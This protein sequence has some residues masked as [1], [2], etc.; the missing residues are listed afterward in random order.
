MSRARKER[1]VIVADFETSKIASDT[2]DS[3]VWCWG[4]SRWH[5]D[6]VEDDDYQW[7]LS[8]DTFMEYVAKQKRPVN[9][10]FH[11]LKFDGHFIVDWLL[12]T[13]KRCVDLEECAPRVGEFRTTISDMGLWYK[14]VW[15][16]SSK[17]IVEFRDSYKLLPVSVKALGEMS[18][19]N[20]LKGDIE[21]S[22]VRPPGYSPTDTELDYQYRDVH[23]VSNALHISGVTKLTISS[24]AFNDWKGTLTFKKK[25][26]TEFKD[27]SIWRN[28]FPRLSDRDDAAIRSAYRGGF[29]AVAVGKEGY[30]SGPGRTYDVNS[31]YPS[32]L[33]DEPL[34]CAKPTPYYDGLPE[35]DYWVARGCVSFNLKDG[36]IPCIQ[37]K[38]TPGYRGSEHLKSGE[39]VVLSF[40]NIDYE[41]FKEM[42]DF[43]IVAL[44][45][46]YKFRTCTHAFDAYI[47]KWGRV[48]ERSTGVKRELA[49]LHLNSLYGKFGNTPK[50][51]SR[52]P[53]MD[54]DGN[55]HYVAG[56]TTDD[57]P[58]YVPLA[59]FVT[60]IARA[61]IIRSA[62]MCGDRF[63]YADT[64]SLHVEG[65][66]PV[67][68]L[69][70]HETRL[71]AWA[72][73]ASFTYGVYNRAKQYGE[74]INGKHVIHMAGAPEKILENV[75]VDDML[76][77]MV[78]DGKLVPRTVKGGQL[79]Q[80]TTFRYE[81]AGPSGG[82]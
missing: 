5:G 55:V 20:I 34:P 28:I 39:G 2:T 29:T 49:K 62:A 24:L 7:G 80:P 69:D 12:R 78:L 66:Y 47:E 33:R 11:N 10:F 27:S 76:G 70:V 53:V 35:D 8:I 9:V 60:A 50:L 45:W 1:I 36:G 46:C 74:V 65:D 16:T 63:L 40:T 73:E 15:R 6:S 30:K 48:K 67:E 4:A 58:N 21:H 51:G 19:D 82:A 3:H 17:H 23:I 38:N 81:Y 18:D 43:E 68:G 31:M 72:H 25:D 44:E 59:V 71:G 32:I 75:T 54:D 41:I 56:P 37:L 26:G 22:I 79:L 57:E 61:R 42:Y 14:I 13:G 77:D 52:T 64:D